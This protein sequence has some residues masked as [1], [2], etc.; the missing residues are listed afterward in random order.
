MSPK[1]PKNVVNQEVRRTLRAINTDLST[2]IR[3]HKKLI[4]KARKEKLTKSES[5]L[6]QKIIIKHNELHRCFKKL[7]P[8]LNDMI[9][10]FLS[11]Q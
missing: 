2:L 11:R 6:L 1:I 7:T 3:W 9:R 10:D 5:D 8:S 4:T